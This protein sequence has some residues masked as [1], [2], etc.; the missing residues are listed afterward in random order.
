MSTTEIREYCESVQSYQIKV[1]VRLK[2]EYEPRV[3]K[4]T[5]VDS[6][7]FYLSI[8]REKEIITVPYVTVANIT[9]N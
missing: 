2:S 1:K 7:Q 6:K 9:N 8:D 4:V 5:G 3:G